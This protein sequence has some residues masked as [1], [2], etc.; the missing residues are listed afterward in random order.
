MNS[1]PQPARA[2]VL[3]DHGG[4]GR[5]HL[6]LRRPAASLEPDR[7]EARAGSSRPSA[8][9]SA[10]LEAGDAE[11]DLAGSDCGCWSATSPAHRRA[12]DRARRPPGRR[13]ARAGVRHRRLRAR[14]DRRRCRATRPRRPRRLAR[15]V[16]ERGRAGRRRAARRDRGRAHRRTASRA[17]SRSSRTDLADVD[18]NVALIRR[19]IL[20]AGLIALLLALGAGWLVARAHARR[21]RRLEEAAEKVADGNFS[22]PI[23]I[24]SDDEVGQLAMTFN[25]MQK[26]LARARQRPQGV[27]RQRLARAAHADLLALGLRRAARGRRPRSRG[28]SRVRAHDARAGRAADEADRRPARPLEAR[29]RRDRDPPRAGRLAEVARRVAEEFGPVA[30]RHGSAIEVARRR[31][32]PPP[33]ADPDRV[34]QIMR[35]LIDNALT[36]TPEGTAIT[37]GTRNRERIGKPGRHRRR[38][39]DRAALARAR[40]RALLHRRRGQRL[41]ARAG[42]RA[43]AG[44]AHGRLARAALAPRPHRVRAAASGRCAGGGLSPMPPHAQPRRWSLLAAASLGLAACGDEESP[45]TT[46]DAAADR[47]RRRRRRAA[48]S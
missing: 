28:A 13:R 30:E 19:Q 46:S 6:P 27:H 8:S 14:A 32:P 4:G 26:R 38:A 25:E 20:I 31:P 34:A 9:E 33:R 23:P 16:G 40:L 24:D 48:G 44:A 42:D 29:R 17:G 45:E 21:L 2:A 1:R 11:R 18:D 39:R 36:H 15:A 12:G 35:I 10:R 43:R 7:G 41:G 3:R 22:S 5:V 47:P 37:V